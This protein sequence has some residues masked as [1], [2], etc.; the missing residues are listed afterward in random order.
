MIKIQR[1]NY[2]FLLFGLLIFLLLTPLSHELSPH[3]NRLLLNSIFLI[4]LLTSIWS[5][6]AS[7]LWYQAGW[8]LITLSF[9]CGSLHYMTNNGKFVIGLNLIMLAFVTMSFIIVL[10]EV[11]LG[12]AIT[13]NRLTGSICA[14]LLL[15]LIWAELY[16]LI[17]LLLPGSFNGIQANE[18][19]NIQ[20]YLYYSYV[21]LTTLGYGD[22][23]P[24]RPLSR[25]LSVLEAV[26]GV[27][28][29][30]ILVS[31]LV[32]THLHIKEGS[33]K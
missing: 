27:L 23:Q 3:S 21:T 16:Y 7:K 15:G 1:N 13:D 33:H 6:A 10:R 18:R 19:N 4:T 25:N 9:V 8:V 11:I 17:D 20:G 24:A 29:I 12:H 26:C 5:L 14:Y 32:A 22:I 31:K 28:Y 2:T 30:A